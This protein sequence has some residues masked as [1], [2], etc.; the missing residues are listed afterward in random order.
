MIPKTPLA[1]DV[2]LAKIAV[3]WDDKVPTK[4]RSL[5]PADNNPDRFR[6]DA[7]DLSDIRSAMKRY[8]QQEAEIMEDKAFYDARFRL[9][10]VEVRDG[11]AKVEQ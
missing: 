3:S 9:Q 1:K 7:Q 5:F 10:F 11:D 6:G 8:E 4:K 2:E